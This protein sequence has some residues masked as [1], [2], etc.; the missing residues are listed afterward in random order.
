MA[1]EF[2][3]TIRCQWQQGEPDGIAYSRAKLASLPASFSTIWIQ[4][5]L[6]KHTQILLE[7]WTT[8]SYLAAQFPRFTYGHLVACQSFRNPALLAKMGASM[9]YLT[10]GRFIMGVGAGWLEEEYRAYG[11][12]FPSP[13]VRVAQLAKRSRCCG[14]CGRNHPPPITDGIITSS[15]PTVSR[16]PIP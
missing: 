5:H 15:R 14:R 4:D 12:D 8:L 9:Q 13:G 3:T 16:A 6:Q 11:Y 1:I 10:G 2:S 7:S